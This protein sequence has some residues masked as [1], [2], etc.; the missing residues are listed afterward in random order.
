VGQTIFPNERR[1]IE[2][3]GNGGFESHLGELRQIKRRKEI[4]VHDKVVMSSSGLEPLSELEDRLAGSW[5]LRL[6]WV[7][8]VEQESIL[9]MQTLAL[10]S[11]NVGLVSVVVLERAILVVCRNSDLIDGDVVAWDHV[12]LEAFDKRR[13]NEGRVEI[14]RVGDRKPMILAGGLSLPG[15]STT[16]SSGDHKNSVFRIPMIPRMS[17]T[18]RNRRRTGRVSC[19]LILLKERAPVFSQMWVIKSLDQR[20]SRKSAGL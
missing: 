19:C 9:G 5:D 1:A 12:V 2:L 16:I 14:E 13:M 18:P 15:K 6:N 7:D 10:H 3:A 8:E 20:A 11:P 17:S 4:R